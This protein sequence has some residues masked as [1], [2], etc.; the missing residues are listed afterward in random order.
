MTSNRLAAM[1]AGAALSAMLTV[2]ATAKTLVYCSEGSPEGFTL[3]F[4]TSGTTFDATSLQLYNRLVEF[5]RG[6]VDP[7][8]GLAES[9]ATT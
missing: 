9:C 2:S 7:V 5:K 1:I 3:A 4:Y 6:T 8:P